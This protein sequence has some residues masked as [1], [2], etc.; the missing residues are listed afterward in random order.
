MNKRQAKKR[1]KKFGCKKWSE[2][3]RMDELYNFWQRP[4]LIIRN[5]WFERVAKRLRT[6]TELYTLPDKFWAVEEE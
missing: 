6:D 1:N 4:V 2:V 5:K 3:K